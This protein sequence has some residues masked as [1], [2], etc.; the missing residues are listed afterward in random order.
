MK[1]NYFGVSFSDNLIQIKVLDTVE[2]YIT[3]G[4]ILHH[5]LF[6]NEYHLKPDTLILSARIGGKPIE[7]IEV[8]LDTFKVLQSRG[9]FN[10]ET[11]YHARILKLLEGNVERLRIRK[12]NNELHRTD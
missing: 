9:K 8:C 2:D 10:T 6:A 12:N 11:K 3:E 4:D 5:C 1:S 7:T